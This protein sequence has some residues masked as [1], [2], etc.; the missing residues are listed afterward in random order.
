M[1]VAS[2]AD[3]ALLGHIAR[4]INDRDPDGLTA[5]WIRCG[6]SGNGGGLVVTVSRTTRA[7]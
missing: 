6:P 5:L 7:V 2:F 1:V 4:A 3:S